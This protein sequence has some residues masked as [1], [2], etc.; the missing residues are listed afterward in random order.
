MG[1]M[2]SCDINVAISF[3]CCIIASICLYFLKMSLY[4]FD[5][6]AGKEVG[7]FHFGPG[8]ECV[9]F[10][11]SNDKIEVDVLDANP[12]FVGDYRRAVEFVS[13]FLKTNTFK[14]ISYGRGFG[15]II[16]NKEQHGLNPYG[17]DLNM[18][19]GFCGGNV[20]DFA[21]QPEQGDPPAYSPTNPE[22]SARPAVEIE[23]VD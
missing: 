8:D 15:K 17:I 16:V 4:G 5:A 2:C 3:A 11:I 6:L 14:V 19:V 21:V 12:P 22:T 18:M 1:A 10:V 20:A 9:Y 7:A 23:E 13:T